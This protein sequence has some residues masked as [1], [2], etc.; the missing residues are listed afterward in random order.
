MAH[1]AQPE[2]VVFDGAL[3]IRTIET[4]Q[5]KLSEALAQSAAVEID[6]GAASE[7]DLSF[8][9]LLLAA[10]KAAI[11]SGKSFSLLNPATGVL[12]E[13]LA[14]GGLLPV[15]GAA[16]GDATFWRNEKN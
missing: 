14:R 10:R 16:G 13:V 6:C 8:V 5:A 15:D 7:M 11:K 1:S 2:R 12:R 4:S 3:T 9:Q